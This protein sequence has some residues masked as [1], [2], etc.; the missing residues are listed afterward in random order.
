[1]KSTTKGSQP[2][3]DARRIAA[4]LKACAGIPTEQLEDNVVLRLVAA[5]VHVDNP[6]IREV[7]EVLAP[8]RPRLVESR[9]GVRPRPEGN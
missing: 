2:H 6:R 9:P 5:C 7:L 3:A 1:M 4:C 8:L